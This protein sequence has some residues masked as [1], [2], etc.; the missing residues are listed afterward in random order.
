MHGEVSLHYTMDESALVSICQSKQTAPNPP[1]WL[2][3]RIG[4]PYFRT[5]EARRAMAAVVN[6]HGPHLHLTLLAPSKLTV[7]LL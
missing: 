7:E 2:P 5:L 1:A 4:D 3:S 6:G